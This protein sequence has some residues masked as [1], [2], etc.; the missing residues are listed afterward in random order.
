MPSVG[1]HT[2]LDKHIFTEHNLPTVPELEVYQLIKHANLSDK[3][4][5]AT[6]RSKTDPA[7]YGRVMISLHK[8]WEDI[9]GLR[10]DCPNFFQ[11]MQVDKKHQDSLVLMWSTGKAMAKHVDNRA[12]YKATMDLLD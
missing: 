10:K 1:L 6:Y 8:G 3:I 9:A 2:A 4:T 12:L 11:Q 5:V 7:E